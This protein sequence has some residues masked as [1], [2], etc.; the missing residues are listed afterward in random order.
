MLA[1]SSWLSL[2]FVGLVSLILAQ[3]AE[4]ELRTWSD[5]GGKYRVKAS[6][7]E[8]K[9]G[10][11]VL[12]K[13]DGS[14]VRIALQKLSVAD[15]EW[16][17]K[18]GQAAP[19]K[20][21]SAKAPP[22][23]STAGADWPGWRG[24]NRDGKSPDKGLL[25]E[26]PEGGPKLLWKVTDIGKGWSGVAV[27]A[28]TVYITGDLDGKLM[29]F[30][31]DLQGKQKWKV[32]C[33]PQC[34]RG[35]F[36]GSRGT[37]T[38]EG[39]NL[40]LLSGNGLLLCRDADTGAERWAK[41]AKDFGGGSGGWGYSES[42]LLNGPW[43]IFKPGGEKCIVALDKQSGET[44]WTS[45]GYNAGPEYGSCIAVTHKGIPMIISGTREGL[46]G[47]K[48]GSGEVLW[49]NGFAAGNVAN[50]P[51]PVYSE[52]YVFWANGYGKG[53]V[54]VKLDDQA[55]ATEVYTT[56]DM[57]CHHGGFIIE[58]GHVYGNNGGGWACLE[59]STGKKV[60]SE[61]GVGK[62]SLCWADGLLFLLSENGGNAGLAEC[63]TEG[64]KLKGKVKVDGEGPSWAH[65][66][67]IGGR[68]YLRYE[69]NLYCF[70]VKA[71]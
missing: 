47:V 9:D 11:V 28:G 22:A 66:V 23:S 20:S 53:G 1:R 62:G 40:Y 39:K 38:I 69:K 14:R 41:D 52:G 48:A 70:D 21:P 31:Y 2:V 51:T 13:A 54:C 71:S 58:K 25:R 42:V 57:E 8:V 3:A 5:A 55:K 44:A 27:A 49:K 65:P 63:T 50:V 17:A 18:R 4:P 26:W 68:L 61:H 10:S 67:V 60:W 36:L 64:L 24:P 33:G 35:G 32:E 30:A 6:F 43:A 59:L 37:P 19:A 12:K 7:V 29:L 34:D 15:Q 56:H 45:Q 46:V 16:V